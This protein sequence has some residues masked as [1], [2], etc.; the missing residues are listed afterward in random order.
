MACC[1]V[2]TGTVL[3]IAAITVIVICMLLTAVGITHYQGAY[4]AHVAQ[5][6]K[7]AAV[8]HWCTE[9]EPFRESIICNR[10]EAAIP[11]SL[12]HHA[13]VSN[14]QQEARVAIHNAVGFLWNWLGGTVWPTML[15]SRWV[16][17]LFDMSIYVTLVNLSITCIWLVYV[18]YN[19]FIKKPVE[20]F[21]EALQRANRTA[22]SGFKAKSVDD[23]LAQQA[24]D[25]SGY[26]PHD[27]MPPPQSAGMY[28][29]RKFHV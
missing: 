29:R 26:T 5:Y 25:V 10:C 9:C 1:A 12:Q 6:D 7:L 3:A 18:V 23:L 17:Y 19:Y 22:P 28:N 21:N 15:L 2:G 27:E 8:H 24:L 4:G 20:V 14:T 16:N 11:F 13:V